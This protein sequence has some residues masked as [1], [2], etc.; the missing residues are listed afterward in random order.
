MG[1]PSGMPTHVHATPADNPQTHTA[2]SAPMSP[3]HDQVVSPTLAQLQR[4]N[5]SPMSP[6]HDQMVP[7]VLQST[8]YPPLAHD[9]STSLNDVQ[10]HSIA[11]VG[12]G[13]ATGVASG[14]NVKI[15][16]AVTV[17]VRTAPSVP[18][19]STDNGVGDVLADVAPHPTSAN[20]VSGVRKRNCP[21]RIS[22]SIRG[23]RRDVRVHEVGP[24]G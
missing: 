13:V 12:P 7:P 24:R 5:P 21:L 6:R 1:A 3:R 11:K 14:G 23:S 20:T 2:G 22:E 16:D 15:G 17:G 10:L 9:H 19:G 4:E 18:V 8:A